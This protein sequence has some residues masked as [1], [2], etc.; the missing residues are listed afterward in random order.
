MRVKRLT[1]RSA[2]GRRLPDD[3]RA[4]AIEEVQ[5]AHPD[6]TVEVHPYG[7]ELYAEVRRGKVARI[8]P[9]GGVEW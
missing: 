6:A 8:V 9:V 3:V 2:S 5:R 7:G 4:Q 1:N